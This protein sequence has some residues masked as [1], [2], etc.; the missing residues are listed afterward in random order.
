MRDY[1]RTRPQFSE[2]GNGSDC[3]DGDR[4]CGQQGHRRAWDD[5]LT[6]Q[7]ACSMLKDEQKRG[8]EIKEGKGCPYG[9]AN[10]RVYG[11]GYLLLKCLSG[12]DGDIF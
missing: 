9:Y 8:M 11:Y 12:R 1:L 3:E 4:R 7:L 5:S 2:F 6:Y 10:Q